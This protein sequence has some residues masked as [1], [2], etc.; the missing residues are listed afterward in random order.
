MPLSPPSCVQLPQHSCSNRYGKEQILWISFYNGGIIA[1]LCSS[2]ENHQTRGE[3]KLFVLVFRSKIPAKMFL[4]SLWCGR[5]RADRV[6]RGWHGDKKVKN[7]KLTKSLEI[8]GGLYMYILFYFVTKMVW[9]FGFQADGTVLLNYQKLN[10]TL[11]DNESSW[12][13]F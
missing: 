6:V 11:N 8:N 13:F 1:L 10:S 7:K 4:I 5:K 3:Y 12:F 2:L 9:L